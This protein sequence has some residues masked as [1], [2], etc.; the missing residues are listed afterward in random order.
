MEFYTNRRMMKAVW[1]DNRSAV[2]A[3]LALLLQSCSPIDNDKT[4]G[5]EKVIARDEQWSGVVRIKDNVKVQNGAT[6][7]IEAGTVVTFEGKGMLVVGNDGAAN[8]RIE[9]TSSKPVQIEG[10]DGIQLIQVGK[11][12]QISNCRFTNVGS[13]NG[14]ALRVREV[15][16]FPIEHL[17]IKGG[18]GVELAKEGIDG[19]EINGLKIRCENPIALSVP[20]DYKRFIRNLDIQGKQIRLNGDGNSPT[21]NLGGQSAYLVNQ[22]LNL[23]GEV[24]ISGA[25]MYFTSNGELLVGGQLPTTAKFEN[26]KFV[27]TGEGKWKGITFDSQVQGKSS[28]KNCVVSGAKVGVSLYSNVTFTI[29]GC[30]LSRNDHAV[31]AIKGSGWD[32]TT[33]ADNNTIPGGKN[34][35]ELTS[36]KCTS[37]PIMRVIE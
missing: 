37:L 31:K 25:T 18:G 24:E 6:L 35:V 22:T 26:S 27:L 17:E 8:I 5:E 32:A 29:V 1:K 30:D 20:A 11:N 34:G 13:A 12:S 36:K 28:M 7:T 23:N 16:G 9:G 33:I 19:G 14:Y 10:G 3:V 4:F 21:V 15:F 2:L